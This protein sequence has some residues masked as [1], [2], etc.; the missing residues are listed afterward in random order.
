MHQVLGVVSSADGTSGMPSI[1]DNVTPVRWA[2][3][4]RKA[5]NMSFQAGGVHGGRVGQ[6][7]VEINGEPYYWLLLLH[8]VLPA[9]PASSIIP[10]HTDDTAHSDE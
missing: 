9:L 2:R 5:S 6:H 8:L 10:K 1:R 7:P 3:P 4:R